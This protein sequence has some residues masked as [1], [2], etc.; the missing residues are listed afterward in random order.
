ME[1]FLW[2]PLEDLPFIVIVLV[3]AF[4]VHEFA[5]AYSAYKF[6]D[7]TAYNAGRVTLDPRVHLDV[8]GTILILIAGFGWAKPVPVNPNRFKRP[9]LMGVIVSAVGPLSNLALA[10]L[11]IFAVYVLN[12]TALLDAGS[13]GVRKALVHFFYYLISMNLLLFIFNLIPLPPLD[14]YRIIQDLVPVH[15]RYKMDQNVQWG[16]FVFL[17]IVFIPPLRAVTLEPLFGYSSN[18]L[19]FFQSLFERVFSPMDW[20]RFGM[21]FAS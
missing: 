18:L 9:R 1:R 20:F 15:V 13:I 3:L 2:Y 16:I 19:W 4:T 11:G 8:L 12:E 5:H 10:V 14:G 6:G 17:L 7:H 21:D